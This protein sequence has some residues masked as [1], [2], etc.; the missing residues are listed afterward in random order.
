MMC[1]IQPYIS[2]VD[3]RGISISRT[4]LNFHVSGLPVAATKMISMLDRDKKL[5]ELPDS[6]ET[7]G[8]LGCSIWL[9]LNCI[10]TPAAVITERCA[11]TIKNRIT[12]YDYWFHHIPSRSRVQ[13][14]NPEALHG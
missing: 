3:I 12:R 2:R 13:V 1:L 10:L 8:P 6:T 7:T 14:K 5:F 11:L 4:T 9:P